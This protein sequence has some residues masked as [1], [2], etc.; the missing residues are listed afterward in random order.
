M[1]YVLRFTQRFLDA[2]EE[3][4][5]LVKFEFGHDAGPQLERNPHPGGGNLAVMQLLNPDRPDQ[6]H[7][8]FLENSP[9]IV[10]YTIDADDVVRVADLV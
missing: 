6:T 3:K 10:A 4:G 5:E 7:F 1:P 8:M 2:L 9:V